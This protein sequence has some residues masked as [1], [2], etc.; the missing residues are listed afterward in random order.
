MF[1]DVKLEYIRSQL[2]DCLHHNPVEFICNHLL[3]NP[4]YPKKE[5]ESPPKK[6]SPVAEKV[7]G[8]LVM[9]VPTVLFIYRRNAAYDTD[10]DTDLV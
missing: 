1:P 10:N 3:E 8:L 9:C 5:V 4:N 6:S 7:R 2:A